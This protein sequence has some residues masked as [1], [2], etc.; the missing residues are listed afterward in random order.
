VPPATSNQ[1]RTGHGGTERVHYWSPALAEK[2]KAKGLGLI[3]PFK[4]RK[5]DR[6]PWPH[7]L[8]Q[9]RRRIET[10]I[11]QMARRYHAKRVW[12]RDTWH[13]ASRWLGKVL[14]H[15]FAVLFCQRLGLS[16]SRFPQLITD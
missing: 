2:L 3:A 9:K 14:S 7:W 11:G 1:S 16:P 5:Y 13:L 10:V 15:T 4:S 6:N 8:V 12:A